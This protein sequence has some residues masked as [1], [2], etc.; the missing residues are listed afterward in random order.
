MVASVTHHTACHIQTLSTDAVDAFVSA[1]RK[2][3][4]SLKVAHQY[5]DQLPPRV[6]Q[7]ILGNVRAIFL[8]APSWKNAEELAVEMHPHAASRLR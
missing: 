7:A 1:A 5:L 8:F 2:Y 3:R 4:L 6:K